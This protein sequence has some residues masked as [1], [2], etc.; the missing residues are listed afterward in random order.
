MDCPRGHRRRRADGLD[1]LSQ[2]AHDLQGAQV[3]QLLGMISVAHEAIGHVRGS[4]HL[5]RVLHEVI[6]FIILG[7]RLLESCTLCSESETSVENC[8]LSF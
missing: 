5:S 2:L 8:A 1:G 7:Q 3:S 4:H 6:T